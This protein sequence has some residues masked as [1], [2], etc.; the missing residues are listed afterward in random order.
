MSYAYC[1]DE[2]DIETESIHQFD[3]ICSLAGKSAEAAAR[4]HTTDINTLIQG[5][6]V[7]SDTVTKDGAAGEWTRRIDGY[8]TYSFALLTELLNEGI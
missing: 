1:F 4:T 3:R 6:V 7:H 2:N 5:Q 8:D